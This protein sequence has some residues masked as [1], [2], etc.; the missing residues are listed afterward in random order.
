MPEL[1]PFLIAAVLL[2]Q[3]TI[4]QHIG[5]RA[6]KSLREAIGVS[7]TILCAIPI[8]A[9]LDW[10]LLHSVLQPFDI[11]YLRLF[12]GVILTAAITPLVETLLRSRFAQWFPPVGSFLPFMMTTCCTLIVAQI[13]GVPNVSF[14]QTI[15]SAIGLSLGAVFLL[16]V[17]ESLRE[18][19]TEKP[20]L[21][22]NIVADDILHAAFIL[23][24]L[25]GIL[26][27]WR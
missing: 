20:K 26:S 3:F 2:T 11:V 22:F 24:A 16:V 14:F 13:I 17:L 25:R 12:I 6:L 23:V 1:S 15:F 7:A 9:M 4:A 5:L 21:L 10:I 18:R 27:I 19:S 8:A